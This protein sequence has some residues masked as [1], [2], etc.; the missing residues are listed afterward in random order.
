MILVNL[1]ILGNQ[2]VTSVMETNARYN[3]GHNLGTWVGLLGTCR[4]MSCGLPPPTLQCP[5]IGEKWVCMVLA[6]K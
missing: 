1:I 3:H 5:R 2:V 6:L 4:T